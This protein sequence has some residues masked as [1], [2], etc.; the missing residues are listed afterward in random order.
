MGNPGPYI[1]VEQAS[2]R[3]DTMFKEIAGSLTRKASR[4]HYLLAR[5]NRSTSRG[6]IIFSSEPF[7]SVDHWHKYCNLIID[8]PKSLASVRKEIDRLQKPII[9][10]DSRFCMVYFDLLVRIGKPYIIITTCNDDI[11]MPF[12]T[13]PCED[14]EILSK[15]KDILESKYLIAWFA[16]NPG[17][18]HPKLRP[19]PLGP[20]WQWHSTEYFGEDKAKHLAIFRN[21]CQKPLERLKDAKEAKKKL[22][23]FNFSD[24]T[25]DPFFRAH[26]DIRRKVKNILSLRFPWNPSEDFESYI[27]TLR[28]YMFCI[29]LPGRGIDTH[30]TWE[31]LMCGTIPIM[32]STPLDSL[33]EKMPV[34]LVEDWSIITEE[35]LL[36]AYDELAK[37]K[38]DFDICYTPYW[39]AIFREL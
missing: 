18:A 23:Y 33:F 2:W 3:M 21:Y 34:L 6:D 32:I 35:F 7:L 12:G 22:L 37:Q 39:D 8:K 17:I 15:A 36:K 11:S 26:A 38:Y 27:R 31:A 30:R 1:G 10:I 9:F 4:L 20:K 5:I 16:K 29:S 14:A 24:T 13:I 19:L 28:E 25:E